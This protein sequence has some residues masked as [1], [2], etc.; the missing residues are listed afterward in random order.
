MKTITKVK[1]A[2]APLSVGDAE[3]LATTIEMLSDDLRAPLE[4]GVKIDNETET[5]LRFDV[6]CQIPNAHIEPGETAEL[7]ARAVADAITA[8]AVHLT[9]VAQ[10]IHRRYTTG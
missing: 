4:I 9:A 5:V 2:K 8:W 1:S 3:K 7:S 6:S 10:E